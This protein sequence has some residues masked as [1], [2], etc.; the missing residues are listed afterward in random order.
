MGDYLEGMLRKSGGMTED[1]GNLIRRTVMFVEQ[2]AGGGYFNQKRADVMFS[3]LRNTA[4][5]YMPAE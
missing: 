3:L 2:Y 4:T 1:A 5:K